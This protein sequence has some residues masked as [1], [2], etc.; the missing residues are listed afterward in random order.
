MD[1]PASAGPSGLTAG[2]S[3]YYLKPYV[4]GNTAFVTTI[5]PGQPNS[6][7][8]SDSFHWDFQPTFAGWIGWTGPSGLG[9]RARYFQFDHHSSDSTLSNAPVAAPQTQTTINPPLANLLPLSTGGTAF[10]SPSTT[11]NTGFGV[12][13]LSFG[14]DLKIH[15]I[16]LEATCAWKCGHCF[17]LAFAGGRYLDMEQNYHATLAN[18]GGGAAIS[19]VQTLDAFRRFSGG[20]PTLGL[21]GNVPF[22]RSGLSLFALG[23]GSLLVGSTRESVVFSQI[24]NDPTGLVPGHVPPPATLEINPTGSR[25]SDHVMPIAELE[26]GLEY[27]RQVGR[28]WWF[29]RGAAVNQTYFSGGSASQASGN[30]S[31]FGIQASVGINY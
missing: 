4:Q 8:I 25:S 6:Q 16:D 21:Q 24:V 26:L 28:T 2:G 14:S 31:L 10:G 5:N 20:G 18:N 30:L 19:E 23:R 9:V 7:V 17:L 29:F 22:G 3:F 12:D 1:A 27:G 11:L 15:S 13:Q